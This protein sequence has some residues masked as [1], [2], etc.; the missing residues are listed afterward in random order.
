MRESGNLRTRTTRWRTENTSFSFLLAAALAAVQLDLTGVATGCCVP[1]PPL[2]GPLAPEWVSLLAQRS[3]GEADFRTSCGGKCCGQAARRF[4][5]SR[6][7]RLWTATRE[8]GDVQAGAAA[9]GNLDD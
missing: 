8:T 5:K 4:Q 3:V 7:N 1:V 9:L 2:P 6:G